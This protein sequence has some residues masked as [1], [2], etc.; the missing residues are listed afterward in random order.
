MKRRRLYPS[1][2]TYLDRL[3]PLL[4]ELVVAVRDEGS[5][6]VRRL[7]TAARRLPAPQGVDPVEAVVVALAAAVDPEQGAS[8]VWAWC[9]ALV[10]EPQP[11]A[12]RPSRSLYR[13]DVVAAAVEGGVGFGELWQRERG[14][15]L[16]ARCRRG[17]SWGELAVWSGLAV[18]EVRRLVGRAEGREARSRAA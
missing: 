13:A 6:E 1:W 18:C 17:V 16:L 4:L 14:D 10:P 11:C 5:G 9:D 3:V 8:A 7:V 2:S 12:L 15:A